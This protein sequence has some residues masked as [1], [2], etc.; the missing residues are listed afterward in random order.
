MSRWFEI[1]ERSGEFDIEVY[2]SYN[3]GYD[4]G[5]LLDDE[6]HLKSIEEV[7]DLIERLQEAIQ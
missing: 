7:V 6:L 2:C 1:K 3:D 4:T 5:P